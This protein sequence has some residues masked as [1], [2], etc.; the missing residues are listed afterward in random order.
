MT[1]RQGFLAALALK[2]NDA[3]DEKNAGSGVAESSTCLTVQFPE[4]V[5]A[6]DLLFALNCGIRRAVRTSGYGYGF[7]LAERL[8]RARKL[9]DELAHKSTALNAPDESGPGSDG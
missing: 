4:G 9:I 5:D 1:Y 6:G 3:M 8:L 2:D 7:D